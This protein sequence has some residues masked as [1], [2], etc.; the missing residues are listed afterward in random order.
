MD[1]MADR[2]RGHAAT[3]SLAGIRAGSTTVV[4]FPE[5]CFIAS[6]G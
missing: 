6:S 4:A 1:V 5:A 3:A 2:M